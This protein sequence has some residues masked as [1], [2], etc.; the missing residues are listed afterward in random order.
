[1]IYTINGEEVDFI[2]IDTAHNKIDI[3][4][5]E[6]FDIVTA[7]IARIDKKLKDKNINATVCKDLYRG[8]I[9]IFLEHADDYIG[10]V[11]ILEVPINAYE[12][13]RENKFLAIR[14][15]QLPKYQNKSYLEILKK[16]E[17]R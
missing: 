17:N 11:H 14:I 5:Y 15:D 10:I 9:G 2:K 7:H 13:D 3:Q 8:Y 6:K 1:M 16:I 4:Y 12:L